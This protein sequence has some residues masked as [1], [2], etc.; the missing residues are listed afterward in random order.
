[1]ANMLSHWLPE[2]LWHL[3]QMNTWGSCLGSHRVYYFHIKRIFCW[4]DACTHAFGND[5]SFCVGVSIAQI[6]WGALC[7]GL[8]EFGNGRYASEQTRDMAR[9]E[10]KRNLQMKH[11]DHKPQDVAHGTQNHTWI[12]RY[13]KP[14]PFRGMS[15]HAGQLVK[16][17]LRFWIQMEL[18]L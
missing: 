12:R 18:S 16:Y 17:C 6:H 2:G 13:S 1:M 14:S 10:T 15:G 4:M 5:M 11:K 9:L 3:K 8:L 7:W